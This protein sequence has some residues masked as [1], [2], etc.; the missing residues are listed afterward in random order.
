[1]AGWQSQDRASP[2][3][4]KGCAWGRGWAPGCHGAASP[5]QTVGCR[6]LTPVS[7]FPVNLQEEGSW[8]QNLRGLA[9][10]P[11]PDLHE[12]LGNPGSGRG[13]PE[14]AGCWTPASRR[15]ALLWVLGRR[16]T[17]EPAQWIG[18]DLVW[19]SR[20]MV[21]LSSLTLFIWNLLENLAKGI[22]CLPAPT[23]SSHPI[24][25]QAL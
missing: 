16:V 20:K 15:Q 2:G 4:E 9:E 8:T 23:P 18:T 1:M 11:V 24:G 17:P 10:P 6:G 25:V 3:C 21:L 7:P 5:T 14:P 22:S 12:G 19:A 13:P